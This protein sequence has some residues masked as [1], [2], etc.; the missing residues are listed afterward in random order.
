MNPFRQW[1]PKYDQLQKQGENSPDIPI[2]NDLTRSKSSLC[3]CHSRLCP[4]VRG[5]RE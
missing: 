1:L 2:S 3:F 5:L 4:C